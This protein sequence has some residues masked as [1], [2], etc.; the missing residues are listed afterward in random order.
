[1][2]PEDIAWLMALR[3]RCIGWSRAEA[4]GSEF[5]DVEIETDRISARGVA[6]GSTPALYRLDYELETGPDHAE[7]PIS[8]GSPARS[9]WISASH[10]CSTRRRSFA[11]ACCEETVAWTS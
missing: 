8:T 7:R 5:A 9:T 1:M 4:L 2:G 11:M 6:I 3:S 10:H